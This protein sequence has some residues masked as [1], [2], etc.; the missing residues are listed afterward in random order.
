M[1]F[2]TCRQVKPGKGAK[3][4][5]GAGLHPRNVLRV[6]HDLLTTAGLPRQRFHD[7]RHS[8]ASLLIASGVQLAEVSMLLG[9]SELR[10]TAGLYSHLQQQTAAK[11]A[12]T[13]D[14][15]LGAS[16]G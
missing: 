14:V 6:L 11:A 7:L 16:N 2:T 10:V 12:R 13:M 8:A 1:V 15:I 5:V 4:A 3:M 9:H